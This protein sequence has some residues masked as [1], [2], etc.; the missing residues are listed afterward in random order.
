MIIVANPSETERIRPAVGASRLLS[1]RRKAASPDENATSRRSNRAEDHR[2]F[3][4]KGGED[5]IKVKRENGFE[6]RETHQSSYRGRCTHVA[7]DPVE[8]VD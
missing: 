7:V 8:Y 3:V 4:S 2:F 5:I 6:E 1:H